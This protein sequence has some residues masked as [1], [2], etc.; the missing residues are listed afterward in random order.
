MSR[1]F[2]VA[3][4]IA[5][6]AILYF[7]PVWPGLKYTSGAV[8]PVYQSFLQSEAQ[9]SQAQVE[10]WGK[11][12]R[13]LLRAPEMMEVLKTF[14]R[15][16]APGAALRVR[17][18][19]QKGMYLISLEG[20]ID[21]KAYFYAALQTVEEPR[22]QTY[23]V[24]S[25]TQQESVEGLE[26]FNHRLKKLMKALGI[27]DPYVAVHLKGER[28]GLLSPAEKEALAQ[29]MMEAVAALKVEGI[30]QPTLLS[31]SGYTPLIKES[32]KVERRKLNLNIAMTDNEI[33][34]KTV[35]WVGSPLLG[36]QY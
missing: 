13:P 5:L 33:L 24:V 4:L 18:N 35:V 22:P 3:A 8:E 9:L 16:L 7:Y 6:I 21:H 30:A 28:E 31:I 32:L 26:D 15:D 23:L 19:T 14:S 11:L 36:G 12:K 2:T 20:E 27:K 34:S 10:A 29:G 1:I 25:L 17:D